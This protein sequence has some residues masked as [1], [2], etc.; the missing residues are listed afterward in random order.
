MQLTNGA[1][2]ALAARCANLA[3]ARLDDCPRVTVHARKALRNSCV[4]LAIV[5]LRGCKVEPEE[6][7]WSIAE[8]RPPGVRQEREHAHESDALFLAA[9]V[10][11]ALEHGIHHLGPK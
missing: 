4:K 8:T 10:A 5:S 2:L 9:T 11:T 6:T 3:T 1:A 7:F